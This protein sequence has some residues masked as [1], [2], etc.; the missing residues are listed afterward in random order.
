[1][2][3]KPLLI[4][5]LLAVFVVFLMQVV[6]FGAFTSTQTDRTVFGNKR[7]SIG[8]FN[9]TADDTI[10]N[11]ISTG[12]ATIEVLL[13]SQDAT[14]SDTLAVAETLPLTASDARGN[15]NVSISKNTTVSGRW[16]AIGR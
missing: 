13:L 3:R 14:T 2:T 9:K 1:M 7:V 8:T 12:L 10:A 16:V 6:C 4:A 11:T 5:T 15:V